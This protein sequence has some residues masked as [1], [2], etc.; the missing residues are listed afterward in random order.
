MIEALA[1]YTHDV[2]SHWMKYFLN[3]FPVY[4]LD[5][6]TKLVLLYIPKKDIQRWTNQM[7]TPYK[8]LTEKE[9]ESDREVVMKYWL[10]KET[11]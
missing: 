3:R 10:K 8:D 2:W 4:S 7:N 1:D 9:K 11:E 6:D 5:M